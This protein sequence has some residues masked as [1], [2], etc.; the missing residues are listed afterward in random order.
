MAFQRI[1]AHEEALMKPIFDFLLSEEAKKAG[2]RIVGP[3]SGKVE[4]RAPTISFVVVGSDG[5]TKRL[6]SKDVVAKFDSLGG[7][8]VP[9]IMLAQRNDP[10]VMLFLVGQIGIRNGYFYSHRLLSRSDL[11]ADPDDGVIRVSLLHYNTTEEVQK[12]VNIL[13]GII[14]S[15]N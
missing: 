3:E 10:G 4:V 5:K 1:A 15:P 9:R 8:S 6:Q 14:V 13:N 12:I 2:V 7:V 11:G